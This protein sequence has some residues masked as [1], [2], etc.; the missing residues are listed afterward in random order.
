M[1]PGELVVGQVGQHKD[2]ALQTAKGPVS[3]KKDADS[4]PRV[5]SISE[6]KQT[7]GGVRTWVFLLPAGPITLSTPSHY[8]TAISRVF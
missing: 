8:H 7:E 5:S 3:Q 4:F 2:A 6:G 1:C